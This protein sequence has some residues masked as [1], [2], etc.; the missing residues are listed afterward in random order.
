VPRQAELAHDEDVER[1]IELA[2][3][4]ERHRNAS[5]GQPE[6]DRVP[7]PGVRAES[8]GELDARMRA[9]AKAHQ[10]A[11]TRQQPQTNQRRSS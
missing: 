5:A 8:I 4:L 2:G 1:R 6:D 3:D 9:I 11:A 7:A 10:S